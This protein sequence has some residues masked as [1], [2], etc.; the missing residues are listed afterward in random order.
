MAT[1]LKTSINP[2]TSAIVD[3]QTI[4]AADV[5][6]AIDD[7]RDEIRKARVSVS[8]VDTHVGYLSEKLAASTGLSLADSGAGDSDLT[9]TLDSKLQNLITFL[10][11]AGK[12]AGSTGVDSTGATSGYVLTA[13]GSGGVSWAAA[14]GG[15]AVPVDITITAGENLSERDLVYVDPSDGEAY[16]I[17]TDATPIKMSGIRGIVKESGG[18]TS[19]NTGDLRLLGEVSGY[20][21]LTAWAD[22]YASTTAGGYTQTKPSPTDG[23]NQ[24]AVVRIGYAVSSTTIM[25]A[26]EERARYLKRETLADDA[27]LTVQHHT[28]AQGRTREARAHVST[29]TAGAELATYATSNQSTDYDLLKQTPATYTADQCSGGTVSASGEAVAAS[30]A[31]D[32]TTT[33]T[34]W[35]VNGDSGWIQYTFAASKRIVQYTINASGQTDRAPADF[36]FEVY[37]GGS[38]TVL[39]TQSSLT[40]TAGQTRTFNSFENPY[41]ETQYRINISNGTGTTYIEIGE[42]EMME[43]AT[44]TDGN[45]KLAQSFEVT[46]AQTVGA[47]KLYLKKEGSASGN[48]TVKIQ[49]DNSG[50][51]SGTTVT[52]GTS[53]TVAASTVT[54]SFTEIEFTFSTAP[55]L[56]GSTTYWLVLESSGSQDPVDYISWGV[57]NTTPGYTDGEFLVYAGSWAGASSDAC[58]TVLGEGTSYDEPCVVGRYSGGTRDVGVRYDD[59][60]G[61]NGNTRTTFKNVSGASLD[62]TAEVLI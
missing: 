47:V 24:V 61:A 58:F 46:G 9:I 55:S 17:D 50:E 6:A 59:G 8:A 56:S 48:L 49:T 13:N 51:P 39:D 20:T 19:G 2:D 29:D 5:T 32:N 21:G 28:D 26:N 37:T 18:I 31:F 57:D 34:Y 54:T 44:Y 22:V 27:E 60:S 16:K 45:T 53:G 4:D 3:G 43:A 33:S 62:M 30:N 25:V 1:E 40:W 12:L 7:L 36:T 11:V 15:G 35:R 52:N 10:T 23:G 41:T 42:I 38:W 14:G